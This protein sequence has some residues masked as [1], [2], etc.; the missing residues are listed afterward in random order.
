M[1]DCKLIYCAGPITGIPDFRERFTRAVL[2][3]QLLGHVPINPCEVTKAAGIDDDGSTAV[4]LACMKADI[5]ALLACDGIYLLRDW[6]NSRG[7]R[8][9]KLVAEG[10]DMEIIYQPDYQKE[11]VMRSKV[12]TGEF[13][14]W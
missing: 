13:D 1:S 6:E 3:V 8:L 5:R 12:E 7:A 14:R 4:W 10:L 9:E 2:E 11:G